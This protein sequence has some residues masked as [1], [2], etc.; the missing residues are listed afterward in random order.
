MAIVRKEYLLIEGMFNFEH[1]G[2][3]VKDQP[4]TSGS[5]A[6]TKIFSLTGDDPLLVD[7]LPDEVEKWP[8]SMRKKKAN[9]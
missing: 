1:V 9:A 7:D 6:H 3:F 8:R 5:D 2:W 4:I